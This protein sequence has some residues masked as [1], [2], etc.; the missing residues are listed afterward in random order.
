MSR[1]IHFIV[2]TMMFHDTL[3]LDV[4]NN[5]IRH[6]KDDLDMLH[7]GFCFDTYR[8]ILFQ[9]AFTTTLQL[10]RPSGEAPEMD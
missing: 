3:N 6:D 7:L 10:I 5:L 1:A 8:N 4:S 9:K 2:Y